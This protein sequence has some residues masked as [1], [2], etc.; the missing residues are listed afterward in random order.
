MRSSMEE[1]LMQLFWP[2]ERTCKTNDEDYDITMDIA[3]LRDRVGSV[4]EGDHGRTDR[5]RLS[6][7]RFHH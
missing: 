6:M 3:S 7:G 1:T 5:A 2:N 4:R